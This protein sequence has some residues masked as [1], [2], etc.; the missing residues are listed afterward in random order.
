MRG[1]DHLASYGVGQSWGNARGNPGHDLGIGLLIA[2]VFLGCRI[3]T[4][5]EA[6]PTRSVDVEDQ[7]RELSK[8]PS[9]MWFMRTI[10]MFVMFS[11][12][13]LFHQPTGQIQVKA[14]SWKLVQKYAQPGAGLVGHKITI[15]DPSNGHVVAEKLTDDSGYAIF[16]VPAGSYTVEGLGGEPQ[17]V[18]VSPG[19]TVG[20]QLIVH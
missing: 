20:F 19:Q 11:G 18:V 10:A 17:N 15:V 5:G 6:S 7:I 8:G 12:C 1:R 14:V 13:A 3:Y 4:L 9:L 16:D 2:Q